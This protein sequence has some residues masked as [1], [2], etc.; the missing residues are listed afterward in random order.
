M[1]EF[2]LYS[3]AFAPGA[4][5]PKDY[6]RDGANVSPPLTWRNPPVGTR[7]L[8]LICSDPDAPGGTWIHWVLFNLPVSWTELPERFPRLR[9]FSGA[10]QGV[11]SYRT[12]GYDGPAPPKGREHRYLFRLYALSRPLNLAPGIPAAQLE[13]ALSPVL[14]A[15]AEYLGVYAR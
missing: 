8:A 2:Q 5:M 3:P 1:S 4:A 14:L 10:R 12:W 15:Q 6:T 9:E 13:Q 11:N 7:A